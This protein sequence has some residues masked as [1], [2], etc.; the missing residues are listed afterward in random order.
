MSRWIRAKDI[1]VSTRTNLYVR[2][3]YYKEKNS[4]HL[5]AFKKEGRKLFIDLDYFEKV[6]KEN[7]ELKMKGQENYYN[8]LDIYGNDFQIVVALE[9]FADLKKELYNAF[10]NRTLFRVNSQRYRLETSPLLEKFV[11]ATSEMLGEKTEDGL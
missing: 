7:E 1:M 6:L 11:K 5:K 4:A 3:K 2:Y 10:I 8:L 9:K